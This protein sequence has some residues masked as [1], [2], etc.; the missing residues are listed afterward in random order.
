MSPPLGSRSMQGELPQSW[1]AAQASTSSTNSLRRSST[2]FTRD[3]TVQRPLYC[4]CSACKPVGDKGT[5][6]SLTGIPATGT[7]IGDGADKRLALVVRTSSA[8]QGS[9]FSSFGV[10]CLM[11]STKGSSL[12]SEVR[13][14]KACG[15]QRNS[16]SASSPAFSPRMSFTRSE[17]RKSLRA[18]A[19]AAAFGPVKR[20]GGD[21]RG[22]ACHQGTVGVA[23]VDGV[24]VP[25]RLP[26]LC[27]SSLVSEEGSASECKADVSQGPSASPS[28]A[29]PSCRSTSSR[30][31]SGMSLE[32]V[33]MCS[34]SS[35][36]WANPGRASSS[37][38]RQERMTA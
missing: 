36:I 30:N 12:A 24:A 33:M 29:S 11:K 8:G 26:A 25:S 9:R 10:R 3:S 1:K 38:R 28:A 21:S 19:N 15:E 32:S 37:T 18:S 7:M 34:K 4:M 6:T 31:D 35:T 23:D 16:L 27:V 2:E 17:C 22:S 14:S 13:S 5:R 20:S